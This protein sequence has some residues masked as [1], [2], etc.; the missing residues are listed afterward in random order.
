MSITF[1]RELACS[2]WR[3]YAIASIYTLVQVSHEIVAKWKKND[4]QFMFVFHILF[5]GHPMTNYEKIQSLFSY[6][7]T[8]IFK[9]K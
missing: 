4:E 7:K 9:K 8:I 3:I 2:Q 6:V 1:L 5:K